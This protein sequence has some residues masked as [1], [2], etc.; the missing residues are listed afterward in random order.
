MNATTL[1]P[2]KRPRG[3]ARRVWSHLKQAVAPSDAAPKYHRGGLLANGLG[4]Q[5]SRMLWANADWCLRRRPPA[6][7]QA[8]SLADVVDRDGIV[9]VPDFLPRQQFLEV[10]A[11]FEAAQE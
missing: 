8:Q 10:R 3:P 2:P 11:E 6:N 1:S 5:V 9:V 7:A 4:L